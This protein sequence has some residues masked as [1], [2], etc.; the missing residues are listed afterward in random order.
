M[1]DIVVLGAGVCGLAAALLLTRDGHDVTVLERDPA[2]VPDTLDDAWD[3]WERTGVTQFRQPHY[4]QAGG[5]EVLEQELPDV[6]DALLAAGAFPIDMLGLMPPGITDRSPRAGDERFPTITARRPTVE[7][8]L[9]RI[10]E[11]EQGVEVRRGVVA[12]ELTATR[13]D[14]V[15]HV[16][17][18]RTE[19]G[20]ELRADLVV[21]AA[22]RRS[23]LPAMLAA[24]GAEAPQEQAEDSGFIYYTRYF[25]ARDGGAPPAYRSAPLTPMPSFSVLTL[26]GDNGTWSVT[27]YVSSGDRPLKAMRDPQRWD[28][29]LAACPMHAHWADGEP[30]TGVMAMGGVVDR[31]RRMVADG[32]PVATGV[33][34]LGDAWA[35]TNPSLG[36]GMALGLLHARRLRDFVRHHLEHRLEMAEVWDTVTEAELTPWYRAT[37]EE[38]RNRRRALEA[39]RQGLSPPLPRDEAGAVRAVMPLAA[40]ADADVYRAMLE[41]RSCLTLP[42]EVLRRP[43]LADRVLELG[44]AI[45]PTRLGPD[46]QQL[47]ALLR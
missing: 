1:P 26:P 8:A 3:I 23:Q 31:Y 43:G 10:A 47:L 7:W 15:P 45:T 19:S 25:R 13:P 42:D 5:R 20:E 33:V 12:S 11:D 18:V 2:P 32:C 16:T 9:A 27:L 44:R 35:C 29:V 28:A 39:D 46:R 37:V 36:R 21:D 40:S 34:M 6:R 22:G 17:G 4:L 38:D 30:L 14:G 41:I 24:I